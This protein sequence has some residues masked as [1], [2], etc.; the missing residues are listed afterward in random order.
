MVKLYVIVN[1]L[2]IL[3]RLASSMGQVGGAHPPPPRWLLLAAL[4]ML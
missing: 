3:D 4:N 1:M 2:E